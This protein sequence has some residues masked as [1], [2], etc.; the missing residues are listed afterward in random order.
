MNKTQHT[1][2]A[3]DSKEDSLY[4]WITIPYEKLNRTEIRG[5]ECHIACVLVG[6]SYTHAMRGYRLYL[7]LTIA[8]VI[9][10]LQGEVG[11]R[12]VMMNLK[13]KILFSLVLVFGSQKVFLILVR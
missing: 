13:K 8:S 4:G 12:I 6:L 11:D 9:I 3:Q 7:K 5:I 1:E 2:L 10:S